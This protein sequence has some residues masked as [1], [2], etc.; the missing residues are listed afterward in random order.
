MIAEEMQINAIGA[1]K[2]KIFAHKLRYLP[3]NC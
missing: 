2:Q 1:G 3:E